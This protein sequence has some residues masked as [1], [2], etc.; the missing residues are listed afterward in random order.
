[1]WY[2]V[3]HFTCMLAFIWDL[4]GMVETSLATARACLFSFE[5][6]MVWSEPLRSL[7]EH[8]CLYLRVW[9]QTLWLLHVHA[10]LPLRKDTGHKWEEVHVCILAGQ[11]QLHS[12][13]MHAGCNA[14]NK[15]P[16]EPLISGVERFLLAPVQHLPPCP[17]QAN[18]LLPL[19]RR[20]CGCGL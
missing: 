3:H 17:M 1:M 4:C 7:F 20:G 14:L 8:G 10:S 2:E 11:G 12:W 18:Q 5:S 16:V 6:C 19:P 13:N 15:A 9:S